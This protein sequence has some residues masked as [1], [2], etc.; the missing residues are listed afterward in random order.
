MP[1]LTIAIVVLGAGFGLYLTP[2]SWLSTFVVP[3]A[4]GVVTTSL[5]GLIALPWFPWL[6]GGGA[7]LLLA[8]FLYEL[9][10]EK[11]IG[12]VFS[13]LKKFILPAPQPKPA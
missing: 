3:I 4:A 7:V 9:Y 8:L 5:F 11:S 2:L 13:A 12:G 10:V 6:I 1:I